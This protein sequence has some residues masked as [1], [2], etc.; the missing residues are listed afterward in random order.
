MKQKICPICGGNEILKEDGYLQVPD[1]KKDLTVIFLAGS[2]RDK[3]G[4][5]DTIMIRK[6]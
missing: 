5:T 6:V 4:T 3:T 2:Q 1:G